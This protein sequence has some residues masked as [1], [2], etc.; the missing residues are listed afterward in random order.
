MS[1][2]EQ[3]GRIE[4]DKRARAS[5]ATA[6]VKERVRGQ[7]APFSL[8]C[9]ALLIDYTVIVAIVAFSTLLARLFSV[10]SS[11]DAALTAGS[12]LAIGVAALDLIVL[13]AFTGRTVGKW[14]TGLRVE[15]RDGEPLSVARAL[16]RHTVGY[17]A[18]LLTLGAGFL[19]AALSR[20]GRALHDLIAGTVV[21]RE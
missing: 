5:R 17:L 4:S 10:R 11:A 14:A 2:I 19:V 16:L 20:E 21:V 6:V 7:S 13:P 1:S 9:G 8:R 18:S 3:A 12:V 15:R